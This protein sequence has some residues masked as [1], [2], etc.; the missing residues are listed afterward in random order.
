MALLDTRTWA[1]VLDLFSKWDKGEIEGQKGP[2]KQTHVLHWLY[3]AYEHRVTLLAELLEG[4]IDIKT[5]QRRSSETAKRLDSHQS[6]TL[7][8]TYL[9]VFLYNCCYVSHYTR[10]YILF[11]S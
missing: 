5:F 4:T 3:I 1:M 7:I 2:I 8:L 6:T 11:V 9:Y 10:G